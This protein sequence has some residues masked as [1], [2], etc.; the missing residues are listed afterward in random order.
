MV[1]RLR[2]CLVLMLLLTARP[3]QAHDYWLEPDSFFP[4]VGAKINIRL[5]VGDHF[6][7]EAERPFQKKPTVKFE[8]IGAKDKQDLA[9][10]GKDD[11]KPVAQVTLK[12]AGTYW[13]ALERGPQTI[14]LAAD[15]FNAYLAEEGLDAILELRRKAGQDKAE[16]RE[17]Y[18]RSI[19]CLLQAGA[20]H[21][22]TW[23]QELGQRLE[24]V[25]LA[26]PYRL[27]VGDKLPVKVLFEDKPLAGA[28]LFAHHRAGDKVSTQTLTLSKDGLAEVKLERAGTWLI[29]LVHMQRCDT[30]KDIDWESFWAAFTFGLK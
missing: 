16:G 11:E 28:R 2:A 14:K 24:I 17:R 13:T 3:A 30:V 21:D 4:A 12:T 26:N 10:A 18:S 6:K 22:D 29:R 20:Q 9:A 27:K 8:L 23:K 15:K 7:S 5:H 1:E 19:K 25:P